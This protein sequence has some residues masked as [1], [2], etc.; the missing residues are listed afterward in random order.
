MF[1]M[2]RSMRCW[3]VWKRCWRKCLVNDAFREGQGIGSR[4]AGKTG[5]PCVGR[6]Q[7]LAQLTRFGRSSIARSMLCVLL[8]VGC[9]GDQRKNRDVPVTVPPFQ[10]EF[11]LCN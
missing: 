10:I 5:G 11:R 1:R 9:A 2:K 8:A 6:A 7:E 3:P 4:L